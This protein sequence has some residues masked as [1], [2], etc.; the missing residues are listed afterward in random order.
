MCRAPPRRRALS[1]RARTVRTA[2]RARSMLPPTP[3]LPLISSR[4]A[5]LIGDSP[6]VKILDRARRPGVDHLK[7]GLWS[8]SRTTRPRPSR[9][10]AYR[11]DL[12]AGLEGR[13]RAVRNRRA[14]GRRRALRG[15]PRVRCG[16]MSASPGARRAATGSRVTRRVCINALATLRRVRKCR[17]MIRNLKHVCDGRTI[18]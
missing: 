10:A 6:A 4:I 1:R 14:L 2:S 3:M 15:S 13:Q 7:I 18:A 11:D 12:D 5:R 9:T 8:R 17:T 16:P